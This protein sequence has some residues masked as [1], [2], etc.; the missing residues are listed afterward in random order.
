MTNI[1]LNGV[2]T[3]KRQLELAIE[4][5]F[6]NTCEDEITLSVNNTDNKGN[7][8]D[9]LSE[10]EYEQDLFITTETDGGDKV[11]ITVSK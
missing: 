1:T 8:L 10:I 7:V 9:T 2:G 4:R 6:V 5:E 11:Y 3:I